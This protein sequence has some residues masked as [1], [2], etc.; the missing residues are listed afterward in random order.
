MQAF[1]SSTSFWSRE[2]LTHHSTRTGAKARQSVNSNVRLHSGTT[3]TEVDTTTLAD[4]RELHE[5][6]KVGWLYR[7]QAN[8]SWA[9]ST[10]LERCCDRQGV[11]PTD[12]SA[13]EQE[14]LREFRRTYHQYGAHPPSTGA[15]LEWLALMQHHGAPTRLLD[16]SYSIYIAAYFAIEH[17]DDH[18]A[19]WALNGSWAIRHSQKAFGAAGKLAKDTEMLQ[20]RFNSEADEV[21]VDRLFMKDPLVSIACPLNSF[22]LNERLRIQKGIFLSPGNIDISFMSNLTS[23]PGFDDP[24]NLRKF[25]VPPAL[26]QALS[27]SLFGMNITRTSL[28]PGLDGFAQSLGVYHP[29]FTPDDPIRKGYW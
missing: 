2:W 13:I 7:G 27:Q 16:F 20:R 9:L 10:S 8:T 1:I 22:R 4:V 15:T 21:M 25:V 12:R 26:R 28:F 19:I 29:V 3:M 5:L 17:A 6:A 18:A 14:L 11:P 23:M 24:A